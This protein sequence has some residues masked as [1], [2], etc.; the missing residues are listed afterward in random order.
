MSERVPHMPAIFVGHGSPMTALGGDYARTWRELGDSLPRPKAIL[1]VSA[2]WYV[3]ETAIT[4]MSQPRTIHDFYG[5]PKPLYD[6]QYPAPGDAWLVE[7]ISDL[8]APIPVRHDHDWGLDHGTWSVLAHVWPE[9]DVPVVQLSL[10]RR[11]DARGH[12]ELGRKLSSLRDDGV[13]IAGSGDW[14]HNLRLWKRTGGEPYAW[15]TAFDEAVKAALI[16]GDHE[17][18]VDWVHLAQDAQ[19]SVPTDEHY[20]PVLYVAAQQEAGETVSFFNDS[21]DGGSISMTGV[22]IG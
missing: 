14:V 8:L 1:C 7:R 10:D 19:L 22:R 16:A 9:A 18:L 4:A 12:Y 20:L 15:A 11:L 5:F 3:E 6:I 13:I 21:I 2:H 17:A